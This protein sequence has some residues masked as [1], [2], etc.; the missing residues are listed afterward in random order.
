MRRS[1]AVQ[2][3]VIL[4]SGLVM[5][6]AGHLLWFPPGSDD[7]WDLERSLGVGMSVAGMM[8]VA[9]WLLALG[10]ALA[11]GLLERCGQDTAARIAAQCTPA[12]MRRLAGALLGINLIA[13]PTVAQ[14]APPAAAGVTGASATVETRAVAVGDVLTPLLRERSR[15]THPARGATTEASGSPSWSGRPAGTDSAREPTRDAGSSGVSPAWQPTALPADGGL[16]VRPDSRSDAR[17]EGI[18]VAPGDS[19]WS[20]VARHL[21]PLATPAEIA[22]AWPVWFE[23]NRSTIGD[24]PALLIP[25][26]VLRAPSSG[27]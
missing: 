15:S 17:T 25:G 11:A 14:A 4:A 20:I 8:V 24:D 2:A 3:G 22:K 1:D 18:A 12:V 6:K 10:I 19:L 7:S 23:A 13:V 26:Q 27:E 21:G 5:A 16:L 9:A